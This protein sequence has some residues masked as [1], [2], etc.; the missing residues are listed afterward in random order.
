MS[1]PRVLGEAPSTGADD[2]S[3]F[4]LP[5]KI[6]W[7]PDSSGSPLLLMVAGPAEGYVELKV[8][9]AT[10]A[11]TELIVITEPPG[12]DLDPRTGE[13]R[14]DSRG[15][16]PVLDRSAW[17]LGDEPQLVPYAP[18]LHHLDV[19]SGDLAFHRAPDANVLVLS[20]R[21][22]AR[23]MRSGPA[24]VAVSEDGHLVYAE[25]RVE[26]HRGRPADGLH[27]PETRPLRPGVPSPRAPV[28]GGW[29]RGAGRAHRGRGALAVVF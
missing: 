23:L 8:D 3:D 5:M 12:L 29:R 16:T 26:D 27:T 19:F 2:L 4:W 13:A 7:W 20:K 21:P 18:V 14:A 15:A 9:A 25:L 22:V 24:A 1:E 11:L 28:P 17:G 6:Q 10:G